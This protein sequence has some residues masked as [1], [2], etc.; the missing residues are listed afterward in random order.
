MGSQALGPLFRTTLVLGGLVVGWHMTWW[1]VQCVESPPPLGGAG[2]RA[3]LP[4]SR[5]GFVVMVESLFVAVCGRPY[6]G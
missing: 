6:S 4:K 5:P 3:Y 1:R 2:R